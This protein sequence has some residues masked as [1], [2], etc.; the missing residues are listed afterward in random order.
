MWSFTITSSCFNFVLFRKYIK[1]KES[2]MAD[3]RAYCTESH[4]AFYCMKATDWIANGKHFLSQKTH[5]SKQKSKYRYSSFKHTTNTF[6]RTNQKLNKRDAGKK[7]FIKLKLKI[8]LKSIRGCIEI[9][10]SKK[11][12]TESKRRYIKS[13]IH[14]STQ[15]PY[16][17]VGI[18]A[19]LALFLLTLTLV[20]IAIKTVYV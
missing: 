18:W 3:E 2:I 4:L 7:S 1:L 6:I 13:N 20:M 14:H 8:C 16:N 17:V 15:F 5:F 19:D 12:T 11:I 9:K 10:S